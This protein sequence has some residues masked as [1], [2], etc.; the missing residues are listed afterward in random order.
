[1]FTTRQKFAI[2]R[3]ISRVL[4][5]ARSV[6]GKGPTVQVR[7]RGAKMR[8]DL[9][10]GM[11]LGVYLNVFEPDTLVL[12]NR[13][14][15]PGDVVLD[16]GANIG[17]HTL[18][19]AQAIGVDGRV[20]AFEPAKLVFQKL[21]GNISL[22][23][24]LMS[25]IVPA[26]IMLIEGPGRLAPENVYASW[27]LED[28]KGTHPGHCGRLVS[29]EGARAISLDEYLTECQV[30]HVDLIK[31]DVDG[32]EPSVVEGAVETIERSRPVLVLELAPYVHMEE[33]IERF[34]EM[35]D[36][37]RN[38]GYTAKLIGS[39]M[40]VPLTLG[41]IRSRV[42]HGTVVNAILQPLGD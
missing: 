15:K 41:A 30:D 20:Y 18:T 37:L 1:M 38:L 12:Y 11:D 23:P 2:A 22:N 35:L 21:M 39:N 34:A 8:L 3:C 7:R 10:E 40:R 28:T 6:F 24:F 25:R 33:G 5:F 4:R 14:L 29:T 19:I 9:R 16:I 31:L 32:N 17:V 42:K 13:I 27:P 26:Q 36:L